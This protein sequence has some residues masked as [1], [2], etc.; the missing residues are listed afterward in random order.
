MKEYFDE[1]GHLTDFALFDLIDELPDELQR[2]EIAEHLSFCDHCTERYTAILCDDVLISPPKPLK[3]SVLQRIR[4]QARIVFF[5]RYVAAGVAACFTMV[6]WTSGAFS[7]GN[8][9]IKDHNA[10]EDLT[11]ITGNFTEKAVEFGQ[12]VSDE[13]NKFFTNFNLEGDFTDEKK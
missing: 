6:L 3:T 13:I 5:N 4:Q 11:V 1:N 9:K 12:N 7:A 8:I 10:L 2:L